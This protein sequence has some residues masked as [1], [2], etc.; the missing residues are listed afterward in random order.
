MKK[1]SDLKQGQ[2]G[3]I[4]KIENI[5]IK[6]HKRLIE[7]GFINGEKIECI[8]KSKDTMLVAVRGCSLAIDKNIADCIF[9]WVKDE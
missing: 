4:E 3:V 9:V 7:L 1:V 6:K 2:I 5:E 8:K